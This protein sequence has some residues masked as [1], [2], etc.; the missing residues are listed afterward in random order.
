MTSNTKH[1]HPKVARSVT[2]GLFVLLALTPGCSEKPFI[3]PTPVPAPR[4]APGPTTGPFAAP[5]VTSVSGS[6]GSIG[7]GARIEI[8]GTG[9]LGGEGGPVVIFGGAHS[10]NVFLVNATALV[11]TVPPH[12]AGVVDI[13]VSNDDGQSASLAN[14][15]TYVS[16]DS[17]DPNGEWEGWAA[18][19]HLLLHFTIEDGKLT[20]VSCDSSGTRNFS[21][22]PSV[23][24]GEF[25]FSLKDS[26]I[27]AGRLVTEGDAIGTINLA[28]CTTTE[29]FARKQ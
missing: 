13:V 28:P 20:A 12:A 7:G 17:F 3:A 25:A 16:P 4:P 23:S 10:P 2:A 1:R 11:V 18:N 15:Y 8:Y 24:H 22:A 21:P 6:A 26:A 19:G 29:W 27:F 9:F 14:A 5:V